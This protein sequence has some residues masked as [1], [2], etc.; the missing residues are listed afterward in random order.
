MFEL[1]KE[2]SKI[3]INIPTTLDEIVKELPNVLADIK[4]PEHYC[5]IAMAM[6]TDLF[7]VAMNA[8]GNSKDQTVEVIPLYAKGNEI[9]MPINIEIGDKVIVER[10]SLERA[11]HLHIPISISLRNVINFINEDKNGDFRK[12]IINR[13]YG[14]EN[15]MATMNKTIPYS[16]K[17][18]IYVLEFKI[19][20]IG[21]IRGAIGYNKKTN[22]PFKFVVN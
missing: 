6:K 22:D 20:P 8:S 13:T 18:K 7:S 16:S 21:D 9:K 17:D 1:K 5:I 12:T 4:I 14:K 11:T 10:A 3:G 2:N 15:K 19:I